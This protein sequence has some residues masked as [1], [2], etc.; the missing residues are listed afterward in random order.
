M[1]RVVFRWTCGTLAACCV[2]AAASLAS[3]QGPHTFT[4]RE[5][6]FGNPDLFYNFYVP[7]TCGTT[8]AQLY[9][10]PQPV[11]PHVG[12]TYYTY[13][14]LMPHE[15]LY[16]HGHRYHRYYDGGRGMTRAMTL[17]YRP[18]VR[19]ALATAGNYLRIPR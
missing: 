5:R 7:P 3:A 12:H 9:I 8:A 4:C 16:N 19:S 15:L 13:Q 6:D 11:P 10:A 2:L 17:Y 18:P 1:L 14:P